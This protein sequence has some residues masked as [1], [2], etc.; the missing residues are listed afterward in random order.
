MSKLNNQGSGTIPRPRDPQSKRTKR[1][2][3]RN[4]QGSRP[5]RRSADR[6]ARRGYIASTPESG[7]LRKKPGKMDRH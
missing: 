6:L 4:F 2:K 3:N 5:V 7:H 1:R